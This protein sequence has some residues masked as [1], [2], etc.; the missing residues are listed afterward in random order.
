LKE[1][2]FTSTFLMPV[3]YSQQKGLSAG[4]LR[5]LMGIMRLK[6]K[7]KG[8]YEQMLR[9]RLGLSLPVPDHC[10]KAKACSEELVMNESAPSRKQK[11]PQ[12]IDL[13]AFVISWY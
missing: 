6:I 4:V 2:S 9:A 1:V 3:K 5:L 8:K 12:I 7:V 11:S 10:C 13:Q